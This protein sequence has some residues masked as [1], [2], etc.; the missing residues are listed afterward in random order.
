MFG[1]YPMIAQLIIN[2]VIIVLFASNIV[3][4]TLVI[5]SIILASNALTVPI[6]L[7]RKFVLNFVVSIVAIG[8]AVVSDFLAISKDKLVYRS[9]ILSFIIGMLVASAA[10]SIRMYNIMKSLQSDMATKSKSTLQMKK[11]IARPFLLIIVGLLL[12]I[13][14]L[15]EVTVI[16]PDKPMTKSVADPE[17]YTFSK[18]SIVFVI[19]LAFCM[20]IS[21]LPLRDTPEE[22]VKDGLL[23]PKSSED[24]LM[25][26]ISGELNRTS[27]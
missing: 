5:Y 22:E 7:Q 11:R 8:F 9:I 20:V 17:Q 23:M 6:L 18:T 2:D 13:Y 15:I 21:W 12:S 1:I 10:I 27:K 19:G 16:E 26:N 24:V 14:E 3:L 25:H 4:Y